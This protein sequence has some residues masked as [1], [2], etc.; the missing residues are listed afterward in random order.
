MHSRS[1]AFAALLA[2]LL[3][4]GAA[5]SFWRSTAHGREARWHLAR[6]DAAGQEYAQTLES[7][8]AEQQLVAFERRREA[9]ESAHA[10]QRAMMVLAL[11]A[12]VSAFASYLLYLLSKMRREMSD[13]VADVPELDV[14]S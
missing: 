7:H 10:W 14:K 4:A 5:A 3:G 8:L 9:L 13:A 12:V 11:A 2:V 1:V 6:A